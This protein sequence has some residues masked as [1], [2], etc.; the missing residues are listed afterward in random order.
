M[1]F[2]INSFCLGESRGEKLTLPLKFLMVVFEGSFKC[3]TKKPPSLEA[4]SASKSW[5]NWL[6]WRGNQLHDTTL[7]D[8]E[9][10]GP[11]FKY[12]VKNHCNMFN[13]GFF[14]PH[15]TKD[16]REGSGENISCQNRKKKKKK[17]SSRLL[18]TR[19]GMLQQ[20]FANGSAVNALK[21]KVVRDL[22]VSVLKEKRT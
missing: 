22:N 6:R 12:L 5:W 14:S 16:F 9:Y 4:R 15:L 20:G 3:I 10:Y 19:G 17:T 7:L 18:R 8:V 13:F 11:S 1:S 21:G 2:S